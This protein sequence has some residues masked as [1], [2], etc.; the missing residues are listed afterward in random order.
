MNKSEKPKKIIVLGSF[1]PNKPEYHPGVSDDSYYMASWGA[2]WAKRVK[3]RYPQL[4][5][6]VWRPEPDFQKISCRKI[7]G[8]HYSIYSAKLFLIPKI[9]TLK[10]ISRISKLRKKFQII[11]HHNDIFNWK[12]NILM[13]VFSPHSK[14]ILSHHG[15]VFAGDSSIKWYLK[16]KLLKLSYKKIDSITYLR[17]SV[18]KAIKFSNTKT[19]LTFLPVGAD[20]EYFRPL[21]KEKCRRK[22]NLPLNKVLAIYVGKFYNLKG[23]NHILNTYNKYKN[24][25]F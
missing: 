16:E 22:L 19:K 13:P 8:I 12:F 14:I 4:D 1:N 5:I 21:N 2:L 11:I 17:N 25:N 3:D 9:V 20:F 23:V 7:S 18:K 24:K 15:G 6:E 10:M